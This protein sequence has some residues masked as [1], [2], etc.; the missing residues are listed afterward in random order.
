MHKW[1]KSALAVVALTGTLAGCDDYLT[2]AGIS[3]NPNAPLEVGTAQLYQGIQLAQFVQHTGD[4]SRH[5]ALWTQQMAGIGNQYSGRDQYA[6]SEQDLAAWYNNI[7]TGGGLIDIRE[8][9]AR[10][11][12]AGDRTYSGVLRVWEAYLMGESASLWGA[13]PYSEALQPDEIPTPDLDDQA[14]VYRQVQAV[15]DAAIA[16]LQSG[17]GAGPGPVDLVY[18]GDRQKWLQTAHTLKARFYMH[19][20]EAQNFAGTHNGKNVQAEATKACGG[21][22]VQKALA[23]AQNGI[24]SP[25]NDFTSFHSTTAGGENIWWQFMFVRRQDQ[26]AAGKYLVDLMKSRNDPRLEEYFRPIASGEIVGAAP[27]TN[28]AASLLSEQR[29]ARDFRQPMITYAENQ[30]IMAEANYR[31]GNEGAALVNLNNARTSEGLAAVSGLAGEGLRREILTEKYIAL[32]QNVEAYN[33]YKRNCFPEIRP[34]GTAQAVIGRILY[35]DTE[36]AANPN[37]PLPTNQPARNDND[38][39]ACARPA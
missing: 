5:A 2:G 6:L 11:D 38:P 25:A 39:Q 34:V 19:W 9:V 14:E 32:F 21:D 31:L 4:L 27:A 35:S 16:D 36:R 20:V 10:T 12:A 13:L 15:L 8:A 28:T 7:Y 33:D 23:A 18:R 22:C 37:I 17:A 29:G 30:L 24:S 1:T 3:D 26:I